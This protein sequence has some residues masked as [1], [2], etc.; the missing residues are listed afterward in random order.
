MVQPDQV[1]QAVPEPHLQTEQQL[2][3]QPEML[4]NKIRTGEQ[5]LEQPGMLHSK[6]QAEDQVLLVV[7]LQMCL[8]RAVLLL[9]GVEQRLLQVHHG[10]LVPIGIALQLQGPAIGPGQLLG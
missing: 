7:A 10:L 3:E 5:P 6:I 8:Q 1:P 4:H 2:L 9:R